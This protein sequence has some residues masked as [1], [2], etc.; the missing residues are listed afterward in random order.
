MRATMEDITS[1]R[2]QLQKEK[3]VLEKRLDEVS[4]QVEELAASE[5]APRDDTMD[6]VEELKQSVR[7]QRMQ[8]RVL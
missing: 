7:V 8:R 5:Q 4:Q 6:S 3:R 2:D 1:N